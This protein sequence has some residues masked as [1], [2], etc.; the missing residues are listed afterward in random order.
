MRPLW[1]LRI[2]PGIVRAQRRPASRQPRQYQP[3]RKQSFHRRPS[4][5][6]RR[7]C[8]PPPQS[9]RKCSFR[10]DFFVFYKQ[11]SPIQ[12]P[13]SRKKYGLPPQISTI[14]G[15]SSCFPSYFICYICQTNS[16]AFRQNARDAARAYRAGKPFFPTRFIQGPADG[17]KINAPRPANGRTAVFADRSA[18]CFLFESAPFSP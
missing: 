1:G 11:A 18:F 17:R 10:T 5:S 4:S 9:V 14:F 13:K 6:R 8:A 15:D 3:K 16:A 2:R 12:R 7:F